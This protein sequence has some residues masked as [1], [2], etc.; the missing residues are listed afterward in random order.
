MKSARR[1]PVSN[2]PIVS[3]SL[4]SECC[5][6]RNAFYILLPSR[7]AVTIS[8]QMYYRKRL[9]VSRGIPA[10]CDH[11]GTVALTATA[12]EIRRCRFRVIG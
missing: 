11:V 10:R 2:P 6:L 3:L 8:K 1:D 5:S 9:A 12:P 4:R 7:V